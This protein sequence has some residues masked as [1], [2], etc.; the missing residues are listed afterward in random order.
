M[1]LLE[2]RPQVRHRSGHPRERGGLSNKRPDLLAESRKQWEDW[3]RG[4]LPMPTSAVVPLSNL[5]AM[6]W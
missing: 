4:M 3:D 1:D 5:S 6:L 2:L